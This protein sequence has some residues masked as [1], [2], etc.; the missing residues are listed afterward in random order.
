MMR[1]VV[2]GGCGFIG[3]HI[4]DK[5]IDEQHEVMIVDNL[6]TGNLQNIAHLNVNV[7]DCDIRD[8]IFIKAI[9][10]F[11]PDAII[12][13]A[14]QVSVQ[15]S[16]QDMQYDAE[17]NIQGS[18]R[19]IDVAKSTGVKKVIFA[20]SAAVYGKPQSLPIDENHPIQ[21]LSP[22][23][24]SKYTVEQYLRLAKSLHS[25]N[26]T[27]LRYA[28]V[29]GPRQD[30]QG[31]GGVVAI[32]SENLSNNSPS[33]IYGDGEQTRDFIYVEDV[34]RANVKALTNGDGEILNISTGKS[35]SIMELFQ[36]MCQIKGISQDPIFKEERD[37]DI[38]DSLLSNK[39]TIESL[40]WEPSTSLQ[41]GLEKTLEFYQQLR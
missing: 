28:N 35:I 21:P 31:E 37:G 33:I 10:D 19:V 1:V 24:L 4:V 2:T 7:V 40:Q 18:L 36:E 30:A 39:K 14:A 32:F 9:E 8:P 3:S 17:I 12:H 5:L 41:K 26:Y 6:V 27:I 16:V 11:Q 38:R 25:V 29:Y 20:S 34:A 15:K 13:Q 23:G 22:Y